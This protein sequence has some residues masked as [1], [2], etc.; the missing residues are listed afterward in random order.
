MGEPAKIEQ[1]SPLELAVA[2]FVFAEPGPGGQLMV[3]TRLG[4]AAKVRKVLAFAAEGAD[5][6]RS[7]LFMVT[8]SCVDKQPGEPSTPDAQPANVRLVPFATSEF[9]PPTAAGSLLKMALFSDTVTVPDDPVSNVPIRLAEA[10]E[11]SSKPPATS[12]TGAKASRKFR[13]VIWNLFSDVLECRFILSLSLR[14][15]PVT[16]KS[17]RRPIKQS[18]CHAFFQDAKG[19]TRGYLPVF[20]QARGANCRP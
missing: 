4:C 20:T 15:F 19:A 11:T 10:L 14:R 16:A 7:E 8:P 1:D 5:K 6:V 13:N 18:G 17:S 2:Q 12:V 3:Y 9:P